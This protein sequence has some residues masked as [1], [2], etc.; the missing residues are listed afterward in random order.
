MTTNK[1]RKR[2]VR[3]RMLKTGER[4]AAARRHVVEA[5]EPTSQVT[6]PPRIADPGVSDDAIRK[7]TGRDWDEWL[8]ILDEWGATTRPHVEIARHVHETY[9]ISGWWAQSVTVGFERARGL[10]AVHETT[11]GFEVTVSKTLPVTPEVAWP[12]L[13]ETPRLDRWVEPGL[14]AMKASRAGKWV[15]FSVDGDATSV[16]LIVDPKGDD[17]S[18]VTVVHARL[19]GAEDVAAKRSAWRPRLDV[20]AQAVSIDD[21]M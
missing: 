3:S 19:A 9:G 11:R 10:R 8:F 6:L 5:T 20:L 17:R 16:R 1:A 2:A 7:A 4:Y 18:V 12:W 13:A 21:A 15:R 14:L